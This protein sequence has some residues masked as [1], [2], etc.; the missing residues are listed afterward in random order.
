MTTEP[1]KPFEFRTVPAILV[2]WS[3]AKRLGE[4]LAERFSARAAAIVTD[5]GLV[6]AGLIRPV[7]EGLEAA[8]FRVSVFKDVVADP[9]ESVLAACVAQ[10]RE[11]R[12]DIVVGLGG[13]S[14]LDVAK[15]TA[16]MLKSDQPLAEMYGIGNVTGARTPLALIPT[17][18]GTGSEVTNIAIL[19]TGKTTKMGVVSPQLYADFVL[20]DA[21][22]TLGLPKTHT[23]ATG[24][25]A[26]VHAIEAYTGRHKKNPI[27]DAFAREALRLLSANLLT[28][29]RDPGNRKAREEMLL[30]ATLA[31]QAFANSPVGA[32]HALA[33]PLGGHY[34]VPHGLS[35][36]LMLG[37]VLRFNAKAA[38]H[39]YAEL[40]EVVLGPQTGSDEARADAFVTEMLR[41]MDESGA[42]R[43]L[44]DV[45]VT[46]NSLALLASDA[47]KQ[48][49]L[50]VNNP[51]E[52]TEADALRLYEE[53]F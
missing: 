47:M 9:P 19:T 50:L 18:A 10:A 33:Y 49:R 16:V 13:G 27:S 1:Y 12:T 39:H 4:L 32:V 42:P 44:R 35:N 37:P 21:E 2:E 46:D 31:G 22:L 51:V 11:H 45:E 43:R 14:S 48:Q 17:T 26:M 8:G 15:M 40:A 30:G 3:G 28:V 7:C 24:I 41:L 6:D 34:H 5:A 38:A 53:A 36:A 20:L 52:V 23:A 29:C 25:D